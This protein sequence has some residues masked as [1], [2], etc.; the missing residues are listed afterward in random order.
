MASKRPRAEAGASAAGGPSRNA[1]WHMKLVEI[2]QDPA[3]IVRSDDQT[4]TIKDGYPK[5]RYH[6]L[7]ISKESI[8]NLR[9]LNSAHLGLLE[10][11]LENGRSVAETVIAKEPWVTFRY[12]Y[13]ASPSMTRLHMHVVSQDL[14]SPCL[15]N[16][17]H[18]NSFTTDF[19]QDAERIISILQSKGKVE[20][21]VKGVYEPMLKLPLKCHVCK[22]ELQ[23]M[24]KL[25]D[26]L[27][28]HLP[29]PTPK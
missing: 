28:R 11:M 8:P 7:V 17:K 19:F 10:K 9:A 26:H 1:P 21:D 13:H 2:M 3:M 18:W 20:L 27:R 22:E 25:K 12:G 14:D 23:N 15:K 4:V 5:A 16:K 6:Y 24:P 29:N